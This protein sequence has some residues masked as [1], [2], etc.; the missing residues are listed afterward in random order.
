LFVP[1]C[2]TNLA[3][4]EQTETQIQGQ[5]TNNRRT[6]REQNSPQHRAKPGIM[7]ELSH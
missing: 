4:G 1:L 6:T 3:G 2:S 7:V 5:L